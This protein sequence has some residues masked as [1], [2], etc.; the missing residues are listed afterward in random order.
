MG[1]SLSL[2]PRQEQLAHGITTATVAV[3]LKLNL[4]YQLKLYSICVFAKRL[5]N[6]PET[7][8]LNTCPSG[9]LTMGGW[10]DGSRHRHINHQ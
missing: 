6:A 10:T 3:G 2:L 9:Q 7:G 8:H 5:N 4:K 1:H